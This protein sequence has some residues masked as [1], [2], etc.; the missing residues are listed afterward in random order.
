M[1]R[2]IHFDTLLLNS[3]EWLEALKIASSGRIDSHY[4]SRTYGKCYW[5][6]RSTNL[7]ALILF[8]AFTDRNSK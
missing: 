8:I 6:D 3:P 4:Y 7:L 5:C 2:I 1:G